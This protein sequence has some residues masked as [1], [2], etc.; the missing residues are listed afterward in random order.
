MR[1][2]NTKDESLK[3][4]RD[5]HT[6]AYEKVSLDTIGPINGFTDGLLFIIGGINITENRIS[7]KLL[8]R[9]LTEQQVVRD[10]HKSLKTNEHNSSMNLM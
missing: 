3:N 2:Y 6:I 10:L 8:N 4:G 5:R 1:R 7:R 9:L